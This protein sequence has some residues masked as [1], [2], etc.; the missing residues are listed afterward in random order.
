MPKIPLLPPQV[1]CW[2]CIKG[3]ITIVVG[4]V[5]P[6]K[7]I[8][9]REVG[10]PIYGFKPC[11]CNKGFRYVFDDL[12][13][14]VLEAGCDYQVTTEFDVEL[15]RVIHRAELFLDDGGSMIPGRGPN[16]TTALLNAILNVE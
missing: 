7:D 16:S 11:D 9:E 3:Q 2:R 12:A 6:G 10:S 13:E 1:K 8:P 15:N 14:K 5:K 4:E